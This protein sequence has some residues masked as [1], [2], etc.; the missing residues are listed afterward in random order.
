M[1]QKSNISLFATCFVIATCFYLFNS[2]TPYYSDDWWYSFIHQADY[3]Y[4]TDRVESIG[5]IATS[6]INHYRNVNG[7]LPVT[8]LVQ[9]VVSFCPKWIFN[10]LNSLIFVI[11]SLL[12][13]RLT[14]TRITSQRTI[15]S[16][17]SLFLL[18]PGHYEALLWA[19]GAINYLWVGTSILFVLWLWR[20]LNNNHIATYLHPL[21]FILGLLSG[22]SNEAFSFGLVMGLTIELLCN[23]AKNTPAHYWLAIGVVL[24]AAMIF[25][26]PGSWNR[27]DSIS[28]P[29]RSINDYLPLLSAL[30]LPILLIISLILLGNSDKNKLKLFI[31]QHRICLIA[32]TTLLP[33]CLATYQYAARSFFGM[34]LFILLPLLTLAYEYMAPRITRT[35]ATALYLIVVVFIG[36]LYSEHCKVEKHHKALIEGYINSPDG[37]VALD[38]PQRAGYARLYTLDLDAEYRRG[39]TAQHLA[40]YYRGKPLQWISTEL[41][42][43]L[44]N[45]QELFTAAHKV[46]GDNELYTT[47][48]IEYYVLAPD[49]V[50]YD[51]LVYNYTDVSFN[52]SVPL[53][54][55][56]LRLIAPERYPSKEILP[57]YY[58]T[59]HINNID[60][61]CIEKNHYRNVKRIDTNNYE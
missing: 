8:F 36:M 6:Q 59:I 10:I 55:R 54:S 49:A 50:A 18:L 27:L 16:A 5:D 34:S 52:D 12:M 30:V 51:T 21:I 22:W 4:P 35:I 23:R 25:V 56:L 58:S 53:H 33:I 2:V 7:R 40:A 19:T 24:G 43:M 15:I 47:D 48:G 31:S 61:L 41:N 13:T 20:E 45:P 32:A 46:E 1:T 17:L 39:W 29:S 26:A 44:N 9:A 3:S 42:R 11:A 57:A 37:S 60:Y 14:S 28:E 38:I